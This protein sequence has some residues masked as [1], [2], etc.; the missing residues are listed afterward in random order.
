MNISIEKIDAAWHHIQDKCI[1]RKTGIICDHIHANDP[2]HFPT[3]QEV[4]ESYPNACGYGVGMEDGMING[5]TM[6]D[7]CLMK[8]SK[9]SDK[10]A[11]DLAKLLVNG[12]L[13][14]VFAAGDEGHV[15]RGIIPSDGK[16]CYVNSSRDQYTMFI[17]GMHR[18][19]GSTLC[20]EEEK[21]RIRKALIS[22]A[23]RFE[24]NVTKENAYNILNNDG[25]LALAGQMWGEGMGN[26]EYLR[27]PMAYIAAWGVSGDEHWLE[28]YRNLRAEAYER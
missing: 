6:V 19:Y 16:S 24:R 2:R 20:E 25:T 14:A 1:C 15:P 18:Y 28:L 11:A 17:F 21:E 8:Y 9:T 27:M 13:D 10:N 22:V 5:G 12:M 3:P 7:A 4:R 23:R 26:H